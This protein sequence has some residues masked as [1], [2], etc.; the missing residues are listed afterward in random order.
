MAVIFNS[1]I[2]KNEFEDLYRKIIPKLN[3]CNNCG[4]LKCTYCSRFTVSCSL[5]RKS[6]CKNC[7]SFKKIV[8]LLFEKCSKD[9]WDYVCNF[10]HDLFR[11]SW[12]TTCCFKDL[13]WIN[14]LIKNISFIVSNDPR[15]DFKKNYIRKNDYNKRTVHY[16]IG[17]RKYKFY[18]SR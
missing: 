5:C 15:E 4:I 6:R 11:I 18:S 14:S 12:F 8:D 7:V 17:N 2:L 16:L 13:K 1:S 3:D 10:L 9:Q